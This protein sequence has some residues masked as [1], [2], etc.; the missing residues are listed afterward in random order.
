MITLI[1]LAS[2][3]FFAIFILFLVLSKTVNNIMNNI[4]KLQYLLQKEVDFKKEVQA[5]QKLIEE[6]KAEE[7]A[8]TERANLDL[9]NPNRQ[10]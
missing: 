7:K 2:G 10:K 4:I 1:L 8:A 9:L 5:I 3:V 6:Q